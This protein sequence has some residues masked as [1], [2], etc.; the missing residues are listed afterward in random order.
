MA[1]LRG[2]TRAYTLSRL[3]YPRARYTSG[4]RPRAFTKPASVGVGASRSSSDER[5]LNFTVSFCKKWLG[6]FYC[7]RC[8]W[9]IRHCSPQTKCR[10]AG[11]TDRGTDR[12]SR[13]RRGAIIPTR[14]PSHSEAVLTLQVTWSRDATSRAS[15]RCVHSA[16]APR[17]K[18]IS[19]F[20]F[21][22]H[23]DFHARRKRFRG[24]LQ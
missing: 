23:T 20:L 13:Q 1:T 5:S 24:L 6:I 17:R 3:I 9:P 22:F 7:S 21:C 16:L 10:I 18:K 11:K 12:E 2:W 4:G 19:S 15:K 14:G 8:C